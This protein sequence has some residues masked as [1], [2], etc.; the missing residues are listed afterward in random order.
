M[1]VLTLL[2]LSVWLVLLFGRSWFWRADQV[3]PAAE[4]PEDWPAVAVIIPA[5]DEAETI[6]RVVQRHRQSGY[7]GDLRIF[8]CDDHS[9]DDTAEKAL[10]AKGQ[11]EV[12]VVPVPDLPEGWSGKLWALQAGLDRAAEVMPD[13]SYVLFTDADIKTETSLLEKLVAA[14]ER[15]DLA[16]TSI[17]AEL[18]AKA[19]WGKLLIPAFIFFFQKLYPFPAVN[20]EKRQMAA[21]AG[22]VMLVRRE[23]L[24]AIGGLDAMCGALIDDCTL[25]AKIKGTGRKIGLYLSTSFAEA[26]SL[27]SNESYSSMEKMV[28]RSAYT[29]LGYSP[30][31]LAGTLIGM[32]LVY[33]VGPGIFLT[34]PFHGQGTAAL[35]GLI[36]WIAMAI[37]YWPTLKRYGARKGRA[38]DLP[39]AALI[40]AWFTWLSAWRHWQGKGG[41]W[42]GRS[43]PSSKPS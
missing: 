18:N 13:A 26:I 11:H 8:V 7:P 35:V 29:Q 32:V 22:G 38:F 37:A 34:L 24:E 2:S 28:A 3:L 25:A 5:R 27:R 23:A 19:R 20:N 43:Y 15:Q 36:V 12:E 33:L 4:P 42:K 14:A 40:Y 1:L 16:L 10:A 39:L 21:A 31:A 6:G 41:Q 30:L 17:M 9:S